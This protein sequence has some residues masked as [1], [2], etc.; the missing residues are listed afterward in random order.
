MSF[1]FFF[2]VLAHFTSDWNCSEP[3]CCCSAPAR[4]FRMSVNVNMYGIFSW[5]ERCGLGVITRM[6]VR[7]SSSEKGANT[8]SRYPSERAASGKRGWQQGPW[9]DPWSRG[10]AGRKT[11]CRDSKGRPQSEGEPF[12][13]NPERSSVRR[14]CHYVITYITDPLLS[15]QK[16][17]RTRWVSD[18]CF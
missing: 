8:Q 4:F 9:V 14:D 11:A 12:P 10:G 3:W 6:Q 2:S 18:F 5:S 17:Q 15:P 1:W 16:T 13:Q 7:F